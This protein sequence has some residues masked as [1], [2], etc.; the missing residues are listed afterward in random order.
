M[1]AEDAT[2]N[3]GQL[4][5]V[6]GE[7]RAHTRL[8]RIL[9]TA[10]PGWGHLQPVLATARLLQ[11]HGH[12]TLVATGRRYVEPATRIGVRA[13]AAG[14]DWDL[15]RAIE[16]LPDLAGVDPITKTLALRD[17]F[18]GP[19]VEAFLQDLTAVA[20]DF[21]PD[22]VVSETW[23]L[24]GPVVAEL[25]GIPS[26]T[27]SVVTVAFPP[28]LVTPESAA[29]HLA[30]RTLA[31]L[32]P[33]DA[34]TWAR[35][36]RF[37]FGMPSSWF[38]PGLEPGNEVELIRPPVLTTAGGE[39]LPE[40][41]DHRP[42]RPLVLATL[43]TVFGENPEVLARV[44][45]AADGEQYDLLVALGNDTSAG[46]IGP[47][48]DNVHLEQYVPFERVLP[49]CS[50]VVTHGGFGTAAA[51][52]AAGVPM[53]VLP[54]GA[55][56]FATAMQVERLGIGVVVTGAEPLEVDLGFIRGAFVNGSTLTA[57]EIR[58]AVKRV[59][60]DDDIQSS[61]LAQ[62]G[63]IQAIPADAA[64]RHIERAVAA[65]ASDLIDAAS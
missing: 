53:V 55:D 48:P 64:V 63:E 24:S 28:S 14:R 43:G 49:R 23:E 65:G 60:D 20:D 57:G 45:E 7:S 46:A 41:L 21:V 31:G 52:V 12:E 25:R 19:C 6:T 51:S 11:K 30:A 9:L 62:C 40:W 13:V 29:P 2:G 59:F 54:L 56:Q 17:A 44:I 18:L 47:V 42:R 34:A 15:S 5:D 8:M 58:D 32:P 10:Q 39:A 4:T 33:T 50:A 38:I 27:L 16:A 37:L 26:R 36:Q 61:A 3:I 1:F 22:A 35:R